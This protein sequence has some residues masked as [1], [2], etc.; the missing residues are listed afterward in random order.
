M[1]WPGLHRADRA[2]QTRPRCEA[3]E[4]E[5]WLLRAAVRPPCVHALQQGGIRV[6]LRMFRRSTHAAFRAR[7]F[8]DHWRG[9]CL[10][11]RQQQHQSRAVGPRCSCAA[12][13]RL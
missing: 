2:L 8:C 4:R 6:R 11:R 3:Q 7:S 5:Q 9:E 1:C 12:R 10:A 13:K